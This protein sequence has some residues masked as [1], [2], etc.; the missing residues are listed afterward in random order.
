ML[1]MLLSNKYTLLQL[2]PFIFFSGV[3]VY[4]IDLAIETQVTAGHFSIKYDLLC[5]RSTVALVFL[6]DK[7][8]VL[9]CIVHTHIG[10]GYR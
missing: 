2:P 7:I 4:A 5:V 9:Y 10:N 6:N 8:D 3:Q 1:V